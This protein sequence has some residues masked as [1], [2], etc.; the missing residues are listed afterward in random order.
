MFILDKGYVSFLK[1]NSFE[2]KLKSVLLYIIS[3]YSYNIFYT[4]FTCLAYPNNA[5]SLTIH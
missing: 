1:L 2:S 5:I 3:L 4:D